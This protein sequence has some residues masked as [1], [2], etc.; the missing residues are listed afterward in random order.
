MSWTWLRGD[1]TQEGDSSLATA[2]D[3]FHL[4]GQGHCWRV[5]AGLHTSALQWSPRGEGASIKGACGSRGKK[6]KLTFVFISA[7]LHFYYV[8]YNVHYIITVVHI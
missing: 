1:G 7:L 2:F 5:V 6:L 4:S 3:S 8:V